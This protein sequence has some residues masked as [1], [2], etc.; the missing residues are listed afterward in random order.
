M[1]KSVVPPLTSRGRSGT[2]NCFVLLAGWLLGL[3]LASAFC[4][5]PFSK[6]IFKGIKWTPTHFRHNWGNTHAHT[7]T[8]TTR[9][10]GASQ[11]DALDLG[12]KTLLHL[13]ASKNQE[14]QWADTLHGGQVGDICVTPHY[15]LITAVQR[16]HEHETYWFMPWRVITLFISR[17][18]IPPLQDILERVCQQLGMAATNRRWYHTQQETR[19]NAPT[20]TLTPRHALLQRFY[21]QQKYSYIRYGFFFSFLQRN[22]TYSQCFW[23]HQNI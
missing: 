4:S 16:R 8:H 2:V 20:H 6:V 22:T 21:F 13:W 15:L 1:E 9:R 11:Q 17:P 12:W 23:L 3:Y 5:L 10:V 7:H 14:A 18:S 19:H